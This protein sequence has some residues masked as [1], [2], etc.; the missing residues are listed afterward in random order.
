MPQKWIV[1]TRNDRSKESDKRIKVFNSR[2]DAKPYVA[3]L[4][5]ELHTG[6]IVI[7]EPKLV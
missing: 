1:Y 7:S 4:C 2:E 6:L 5:K 3:E